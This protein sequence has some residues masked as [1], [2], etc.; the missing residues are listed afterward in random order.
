ME[1]RADGGGRLC[2]ATRERLGWLAGL[3][4][5]S[6]REE[7]ILALLLGLDDAEPARRWCSPRALSDLLDRDETLVAAALAP[8]AQLTQWGLVRTDGNRV[9]VN[10]RIAQ[11]LLG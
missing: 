3:C 10:L 6:A 11:F 1:M 5:L 7:H 8:S 4:S 2:R 9:T